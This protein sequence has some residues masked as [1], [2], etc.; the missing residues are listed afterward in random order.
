[1]L[2]VAIAVARRRVW[3]Q[4]KRGRSSAEEAR[5][6][7]EEVDDS[8]VRRDLEGLAETYDKLD[9]RDT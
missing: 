3:K 6:M 7:A 2:V 9:E 8:G 5:R 4:S 1:M